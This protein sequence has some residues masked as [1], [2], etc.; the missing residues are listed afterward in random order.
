MPAQ[1][2]HDEH[3]RYLYKKRLRSIQWND[4]APGFNSRYGP[5]KNGGTEEF[6]GRGLSAQWHQGVKY[7]KNKYGVG[8]Y[9]K[10]L[11][12]ALA[13]TDHSRRSTAAVKAA[14][15]PARQAYYQFMS[16]T[17]AEVRE[18]AEEKNE[19]PSGFDVHSHANKAYKDYKEKT[20][21]SSRHDNHKQLGES[22]SST[23][24]ARDGPVVGSSSFRSHR[25]QLATQKKIIQG[26]FDHPDDIGQ[27][28]ETGDGMSTL[29]ALL[30]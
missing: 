5:L 13:K 9:L 15:A 30:G 7:G 20:S 10:K 14:Q 21:H 27:T 8:K 17:A 29:D 4:I 25:H 6:D 24:P 1:V 28:S 2:F 12:K 11:E 23:V 16:N 18:E 22:T 26:A 19:R 3:Y